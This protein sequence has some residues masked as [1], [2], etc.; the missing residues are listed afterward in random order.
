MSLQLLRRGTRPFV[1]NFLFWVSILRSATRFVAWH[2]N[3]SLGEWDPAS[4]GSFDLLRSAFY[5]PVQPFQNELTEA[6][7]LVTRLA[8]TPPGG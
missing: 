3:D 7:A 4:F 5:L 8:V 1:R 2:G 6:K